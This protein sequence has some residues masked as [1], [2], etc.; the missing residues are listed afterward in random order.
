VP[1]RLIASTPRSPSNLTV[2]PPDGAGP[3]IRIFFFGGA[4]AVTGSMYVLEIAGRRILLECG[5]FQGRRRE[6]EERNRYFPF[7]PRGIDAMVLS[8][9]HIDHSGNIPSLVAQGF[10]GPIFATHAT[11]DLC[12]IMLRD[13]GRIHERDAE[14]YTRKV[15]R[16][17]EPELQPLYTEA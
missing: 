6:A 10:Q 13:S 2:R 17:G 4:R 15:R 16:R 14:W 1:G 11:R 5:L 8:H 3:P 12:A 9:A 7:D